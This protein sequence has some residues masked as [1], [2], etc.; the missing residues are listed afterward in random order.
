MSMTD[1]IH[2]ARI[3][4][5]VQYFNTTQMSVTQVATSVGMDNFGYFSRIFRREIRM[6]PRE[7]KKMVSAGKVG[8]KI[9]SII[10]IVKKNHSTK[11]RNK[12]RIY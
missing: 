11:N 1:Y 6:S 5:A 3:R 10:V 4:A 12:N 9:R 7:Y 2:H 8:N